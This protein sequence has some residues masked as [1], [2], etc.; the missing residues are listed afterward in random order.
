MSPCSTSAVVLASDTSD[1]R[2]RLQRENGRGGGLE[3][4]GMTTVTNSKFENCTASLAGGA[5][6]VGSGSSTFETV[7][8]T[9]NS[10]FEG[11]AIFAQ[12]GSVTVRDSTFEDN[13]ASSTVGNPDV[14]AR[15]S[16]SVQ[17][18]GNTGGSDAVA[19][20]CSAAVTI[21]GALLST[22]LALGAAAVTLLV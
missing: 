15:A 6:Y 17:G 5:V 9:A 19:G 16:A 20:D 11:G 1:S 10:A 7:T 8:F 21:S 13:V 14:F 12:G 22:V 3:S 4:Y 2:R 18:C